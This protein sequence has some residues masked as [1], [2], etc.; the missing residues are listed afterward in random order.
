M[1]K[2]MFLMSEIAQQYFWCKL[3]NGENHIPTHFQIEGDSKDGYR[4]FHL[5]DS[6]CGFDFFA[7]KS[8]N[9]CISVVQDMNRTGKS[10]YQNSF[11]V[12]AG[13]WANHPIPVLS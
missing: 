10:Y 7:H 9:T 6:F 11:S 13:A 3:S 2:R 8:L 1:K 12:G 4:I 5:D